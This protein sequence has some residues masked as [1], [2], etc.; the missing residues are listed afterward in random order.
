MRK[1]KDADYMTRK[2]GEAIGLNEIKEATDTLTKYK[3]GKSNLER[4]VVEDEKW[5]KLQH[6]DVIRRG[7][8]ADERGP[9]PTSAYLFNS[10][11][12]KHADA[13]DNY[14]ETV[15]LPREQSDEESAKTL[16]EILP[17]MYEYNDFE[18]A[19][20]ANWWEKL[21]HGTA[22]YGVFWDARKDNGIG[23]IEIRPIDLTKIFWEPGITDIQDSKN[24]FIVDLVDIDVLDAMY[25]DHKGKWGTSV[26]VG[27][28]EY[29]DAVDTS[30]KAVVVDWYYKVMMPSGQTVLQYVKFC[31]NELLYASENDAEY[32]NKGFYDDGEYPVVFDVL[33]PDKGTPAGFGYVALC[34]SP[35]IYID[36]LYGNIIETSMMG[37]KRRYFVSSSTNVNKEQYMDWTQPIVEVE[38]EISDARIKEINVSP[39]D[40]IY[41]QI[42]QMKVEEMKDTAANRDVNSGGTGSGVT[43]AAAIAALQEAGNKASRD[44]IAASYRAYVKI[45]AMCIERMRQFYDVARTFRITQPNGVGYRFV[46]FSNAQLTDQ[47]TGQ[48]DAQGAELVRRP[49]FDLKIKAQKKN[50]FS[51]VTQNEMAKELYGLGF[52]DPTKAQESL[53]ALKL[54]DFE[55]I[56]D[57]KDYV[58]QGQTLL[59]M[60]Q[61][62]QAEN[63]KLKTIVQSLTGRN[64]LEGGAGAIEA[65]QS[66]G[67]NV[68][69]P[70]GADGVTGE[71]LQ[72]Q[73]P[74]TDYGERLAQ[75]SVP[76]L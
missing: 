36:K 51:Q 56:E 34:K 13:M 28:Y 38:G 32:M 64:V 1:R 12:N 57:V 75:R 50:P 63:V 20:S 27:Q 14:P 22:V 62:A 42:V 43:A 39:L 45:S 60:L 66:T 72:A 5:Y 35:Q 37:S 53:G 54:M 67:G 65:P 58:E 17:V 3:Q 19:Y 11:L 7:I 6:W 73:T 15:V 18:K 21:K 33:F 55:G 76:Q 48:L 68:Q 23:D 70:Q 69:M 74:M 59:T 61:Q 31:G 46:D 9:E 29:D 4:R 44:M 16:S 10:I 49:V 40:S 25:P 41:A 24:L 8:P 26:D 30:D 71:I 2:P 47:P 52:F